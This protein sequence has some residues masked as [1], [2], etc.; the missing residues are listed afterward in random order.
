MLEIMMKRIEELSKKDF[1]DRLQ[2]FTQ[3]LLDLRNIDLTV[4]DRTDIET[5]L[6]HMFMIENKSVME[7]LNEHSMS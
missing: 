2:Y 5:Q 4:A 1:A 7:R 6:A 3:L